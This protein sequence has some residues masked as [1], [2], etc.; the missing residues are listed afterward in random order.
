MAALTIVLRRLETRET[1]GPM[2]DLQLSRLGLG[3]V[4]WGMR[5]GI[6][7]VTGQPTVEEVKALLRR[8][9]AAGGNALDTAC[10]GCTAASRTTPRRPWTRRSGPRS[11]ASAT[12]AACCTWAY[13]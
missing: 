3:T 5:Y 10:R 9:A 2:K 6:A 12:P 13:R 11:C 7:N 4:Q 1:D 8:A